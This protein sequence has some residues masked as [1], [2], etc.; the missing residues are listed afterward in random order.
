MESKAAE[1]RSS[2][3]RAEPQEEEFRLSEK[4]NRTRSTILHLRL[5]LRVQLL[6]H[7]QKDQLQLREF[8]F[9]L[10]RPTL[11]LLH[12]WHHPHALKT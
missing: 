1:G 12:W 11:I 5:E 8:C 7:G 6:T 3:R 10:E 4:S 9:G 2:D